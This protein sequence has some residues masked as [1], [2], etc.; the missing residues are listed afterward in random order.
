M[1]FS[2]KIPTIVGLLLLIGIIGSIIVLERVFRSPSTASESS[3]P[4]NITI[5]NISDTSFT[6]TWTTQLAA[7]GTIL[8]STTGKSNRIY[9]DERDSTGKLGAYTTHSITVRDA[10]PGGAYS[11]SLLSGGKQYQDGGNPFT[12]QTPPALPPNSNG[13]EPAYGTIR[14]TDDAPLEGALVYVTVEGGQELS[15]LTKPS[16]LWLIPLNQIRTGDFS[17]YLPVAERMTENLSVQ[18][19]ELQSSAVTDTLNDSPVPD[20]TVGKTYDFRKQQAKTSASKAVA[21]RPADQLPQ[22]TAVLGVTTKK[23]FTVSLVSPAEGSALATTF[24]YVQGTGIPGTFV[25]IS[26][27]ITHIISG[28]SK[29]DANGLWTF[30]PPKALSPGKQSVTIS[31]VD[32]KGKPAAI[33]HTFTILKSGT[34]VLGDATP[35]A[36]LAPTVAT[37]IEPTTETIPESTLSGEPPPTSGNELP[38]ILMI[39]LGIG[40]CVVGTIAVL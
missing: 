2:T 27:G 28:S 17:D 7:T 9:Y 31:A 4:D 19:N 6:F 1:K 8:V 21:L 15:A 30:T 12:V 5:T 37:T 11:I 33:T 3:Q 25:G 32:D 20:M 29:V 16:G 14:G 24:P 40:L 26:L 34:Q 23:S 36:T 35:S 38:T 22:G 13:L 10:A 18:A 39:L